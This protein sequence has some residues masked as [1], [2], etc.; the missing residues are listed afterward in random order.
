MMKKLLILLLTATA[1]AQNPQTSTAPIFSVN[2]RYVQGAGIGYWPTPGTGLV[3]NIA[4]GRSRCNNTMVSY[5]GGTLTLTDNITN[6]VYLDSTAS[7]V[8]ASNTTGYT[9]AL[10]NLATVVTSGGT[11][12][13][14]TD[15][16]T[17]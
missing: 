17:F 14:I 16:R 4:A 11:I 3:L 1:F 7:C 10:V 5:A 6:Y 12:A 13:S 2:S 15:D 8:P 9:L